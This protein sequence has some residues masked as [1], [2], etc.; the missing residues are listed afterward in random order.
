MASPHGDE[1]EAAT[2][3]EVRVVEH[4][5][6]QD[7]V[8]CRGHI[9]ENV[10]EGLVEDGIRDVVLPPRGRCELLETCHLCCLCLREFVADGPQIHARM[11]HVHRDEGENDAARPAALVVD[12]ARVG[13]EQIH[14]TKDAREDDHRSPILHDCNGDLCKV[15]ACPTADVLSVQQV[16]QEVLRPRENREAL[17]G[18]DHEE[19]LVG[20]PDVV[21]RQERDLVRV[22]TF[23]DREPHA[24][25]DD[26]RVIQKCRSQHEAHHS[27]VVEMEVCR[28]CGQV[29][30]EADPEE[31]GPKPDPVRQVV[32]R[33]DQPTPPLH[34]VGENAPETLSGTSAHCCEK[35]Q[36]EESE[37]ARGH[38]DDELQGHPF[39][40]LIRV[41]VR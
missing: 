27:N 39:V 14:P 34:L 4:K 17:D 35:P 9:P 25:R 3:S 1:G 38:V 18:T 37:D 33:N 29:D 22:D 32:E 2:D 7:E 5:D 40:H 26:Q 8:V 10:G 11:E 16:A 20:A 21:H 6:R 12:V 31:R 28:G 36:Q 13:R 19:Q 41:R 15:A 30:V 24:V 23:H